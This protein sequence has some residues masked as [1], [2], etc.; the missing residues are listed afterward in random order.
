MVS[1]PLA[2]AVR[3]NALLTVR[4]IQT[5]FK[6]RARYCGRKRVKGQRFGTMS[7]VVIFG[8]TGLLGLVLRSLSMRD[9]GVGRKAVTLDCR[10]GTIL[11]ILN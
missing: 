3:V 7:M 10:G 2:Q 1:L 9:R 11:V 6:G 5:G 4:A 8:K